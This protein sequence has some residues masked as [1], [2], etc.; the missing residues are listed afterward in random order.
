MGLKVASYNCRGLPKDKTQLQLRP[1]I[2]EL[3][4]NNHIIAFQ[5]THYSVQQ[6]KG[7]NSL[8]NGF[9]GFGVAKINESENIIHGRYSGGVAILWKSE[10]SIHIKKIEMDANWCVAIEITIESIK[11]IILNVYLPYQKHEHED[12]YLEQLGYI[13]SFI[14]EINST[15]LVI[16]GDFNANLGL[17]G[18]KLFTNHMTEFCS[19]NNMLISSQILLPR[20]SY[21]YV[22][23]REGISHYSW[24]D[25]VVS[26]RDFHNCINNIS[27]L[28]D[29]SDEDH[30]PFVMDLNI[31]FLPSLTLDNND[32]T[33]KI[34]WDNIKECD[35][36]KYLNLTDSNFDNIDIPVEAVICK[37]PNCGNITHKELLDK[38]FCDI[39][40]CLNVSSEHLLKMNKNFENKPGWSDYVSD[41]YK[42][43]KEMR[44]I[45]ID[46]GKPRQGGLFHE[47]LR[48]KARFKYALR[49]IRKNE[50]ILRKESL[51]KKMTKLNSNDFWKEIAA[52]NNSKTPLPCIIE[53]ANG[54]QEISKLWEKQYKGIFN[55]LQKNS[56]DCNMPLNDTF[57]SIKVNICEVEDAIK[58]LQDNKSCGLDGIYAEHI[59]YASGKLIPLLSMCFTGLFVHGFLP[60]SLMS[61]VLIPIIKN[62][63]GNISSKDNYRP[64]AL[65]SIISKLVEVII[66]NRIENVLNTN[67]NQFGFKKNHGTDHCIYVLKEILNLYKSL[68]SCL[69]VCFL[70]ASK[71]FDRVNHSILFDKL[72]HRG[73]PSYLLRILVFWYENQTMCVRWGKFLS[74]PFTVSNGVRQGGILSPLLFNVYVDDLSIRLNKLNIGCTIGGTIINHILYADD[75]VLISPS[76][77][78]LSKLLNDCQKYGIECD[79]VFNSK[80]SAI[81]FFKPAYMQNAIMPNFKINDEIIQ[82]FNKYTYLGHIITDTLS[83]DLDIY[84]QRKK[85]FSQ[86]NSLL[87]K[88]FMCTIEVKS[89]LFRSYCSSFYTAQLWTNYSQTAIN[90]L[91]IAYH[92]T[93]KFF[94]GLNKREHTRPICVGLNV[95]Y[96]PALIRNLVYKFMNRLLMSKNMLIKVICDSSCFYRS[97][98][99]KHWRKLL[100]VNGIG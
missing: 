57:N 53:D 12:L 99:W 94:I 95:K 77:H 66:L 85:I 96:C 21:S 37:D 30:I 33:A 28:Y 39:T 82:V 83:D 18:T 32:F 90:K 20:D 68:N 91:Y 40:N 56:Y 26:S 48:S 55:C 60:S 23:T 54:P 50:T 67:D 6:L 81:M 49:Y 72:R 86:G 61:V 63:C 45:W 11:F 58:T 78:G 74:E 7:I 100:Y 46:N 71:A 42:Y 65:A 22:C 62:K 52:I 25:H 98:M 89:T 88:F 16:L 13:K 44:H 76:T 27:F 97:T 35:L 75:L 34:S 10:L 80:K 15:S 31:A 29:L 4:E 38:F 93:L 36:R 47:Y 2:M 64:I 17:M 92:N 19:D 73:I 43:S 9:V 3:F 70:D 84:R 14:D 24:L 8:H 79:I 5:E 69:S 51:A 87:R 59:K 1:D 41:L